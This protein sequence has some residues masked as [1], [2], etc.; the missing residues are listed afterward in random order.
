MQILRTLQEQLTLQQ[1]QDMV[2]TVQKN[3]EGHVQYLDFIKLMAQHM[4]DS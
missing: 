1:L 3:D 2:E 4:R